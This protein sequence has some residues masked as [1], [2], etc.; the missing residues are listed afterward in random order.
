M[1]EM[2]LYN[3]K[4]G[5][6]GFPSFPFLTHFRVSINLV[7]PY[8]NRV[9]LS[10]SSPTLDF[11]PQRTANGPFPLADIFMPCFASLQIST[12]QQLE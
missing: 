6:A 3:C 10:L 11:V 2:T 9:R 1:Q 12:N 4:E 8:N 7:L 5:A